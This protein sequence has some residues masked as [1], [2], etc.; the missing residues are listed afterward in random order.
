[1]GNPPRSASSRDGLRAWLGRR[2]CAAT[3]AALFSSGVFVQDARADGG[4]SPGV[5]RP[6][7]RQQD[8][9]VWP[10]LTPAG[11][12]AGG[13]PLHRPTLAEPQ[14][15]AR[16]QELDAT[17]RDAAQDLGFT[18]DLGDPGP[19][20]GRT[21]DTDMIARAEKTRAG[22]PDGSGT[23]VVSGRLE[24][25][26]ADL[27]LLRV[28][29]VPPNGSELRVR[30]ETVKGADI[31]VR[32]LVMLRDLLTPQAAA[33]AEAT[34]RELIRFDPSAQIGVTSPLRSQGRAI[35][36][37]NGALFGAFAA[38]SIT[39]ASTAAGASVDPRVLYPLLALGTGVGLGSALLVAE[40]WDITSG[41]A[42]YLAAGAWWGGLGGLFVANGGNVAPFNDR[43][44]WGVVGGLGGL[45]LATVGLTRK[46]VDEGGAALTHSGAGLGLVIGS[47]VEF[48]F[49]GSTTS[50][51]F[52]GAG[53]GSLI[54]LVGAGTTALFVPV[55]AS[56]I[57]L[58]DL[59]TA[60][61][62]LAGAAAGSPLIFQTVTPARTQGFVAAT[63]G[64]M[65]VGGGTAWLL[66]GEIGKKSASAPFELTPMAGVIGQSE[67]KGGS[68]PAYG[69]GLA[70]KF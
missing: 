18:L 65:L 12:D 43:Y 23:W 47:F 50:T 1:V 62:G 49:H 16:F 58:V 28:V 9:V 13:T 30:V 45:T 29:V 44:S 24:P 68:V 56:R 64:G 8:A 26:S 21:R 27:F 48:S 11:D 41:D 69:I 59:G 31:P 2:A 25:V 4:G 53:L 33:L 32:G 20:P 55:S 36:A 46:Q 52:T 7:P 60:L 6:L 3:C 51:P 70:G 67:V 61:G 57:L 42:W 10:T 40:E 63:L 54:G 14:L 5:A 39:T 34:H 19:S 17:L 38:F 66:T 35:L 22:S 15:A 37:V